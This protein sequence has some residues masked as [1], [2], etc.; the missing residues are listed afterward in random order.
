MRFIKILITIILT[1]SLSF[2]S[3]PHQRN[4]D[5]TSVLKEDTGEIATLQ[6]NNNTCLTSSIHVDEYDEQPMYFYM[7]S[8]RQI[9][10]DDISRL[11]FDYGFSGSPMKN[12]QE[13]RALR[14]KAIKEL[15]LI[16]NKEFIN[17]YA[18][19]Q[20]Q[21]IYLGSY[22]TTLIIDVSQETLNKIIN[23]PLV[24]HVSIYYPE[25][26]VNQEQIK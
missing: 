5:L 18:L 23:D 3:T 9:E 17:K 4:L 13:Y 20:N 19:K 24:N 26:C 15:T 1:I 2:V 6:M 11:L 12:Q 7:V 14:L 25:I 10:T 21:I 16:I 22:T 8:L